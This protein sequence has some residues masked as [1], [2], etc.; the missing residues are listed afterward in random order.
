[1][2]YIF[3]NVYLSNLL[4][5]E[6]DWAEMVLIFSFL[7][8]HFVIVTILFMM[9]ASARKKAL[10]KML[11]GYIVALSMYVILELT[12]GYSYI[13]NK[14]VSFESI[15]VF[16]TL[17][18]AI[19][20]LSTLWMNEE[21]RTDPKEI[22]YYNYQNIGKSKLPYFVVLILIIF[23]I[24]KIVSLNV[25]I[26]LCILSLF[27]LLFSK[28]LQNL[29]LKE[30]LF[31]K[32]QLLNQNL[33]EVIY[34]R[35]KA[36]QDANKKLKTQ[37]EVDSLS[38]LYN[39]FYFF[40][41]IT[42]TIEKHTKFTVLYLDLNKFKSINDLHGHMIGDHVIK[43]IS[44]RLNE[45]SCDKCIISRIGGDEFGVAV[46]TVDLHEVELYANKI[47]QIIE[48]KIMYDEFKFNISASIGIARY[49]EDAT[50]ANDLVRY[51]DLSMYHSKKSDG[52][53]EIFLYNHEL[54]ASIERRKRI[55]WLLGHIDYEQEFELHYQPQYDIFNKKLLGMEALIRWQ[56]SEL[57]FISPAE[58][59]PIAE[60]S[61]YILSITRWVMD[62]AMKKI[63]DWNNRYNENWKMSI[64]ISAKSFDSI[65]FFNDIK[66][67]ISKYKINTKWLDF[68]LTEH[69]AMSA[70]DN[71]VDIFEDLSDL[72]IGVSI[73][74]FGT[75]YS[76]LSYLKKF[77]VNR[78]KI[79][80]ELVDN[81]V[82]DYKDQ[83]I[84]QAII[85]MAKG[86]NLSVIAEGVE[87]QAQLNIL[88]DLGC[89]SI[90]GYIWGK[91]M[92][93]DI[94]ENL[95]IKIKD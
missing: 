3:Y 72:G 49:P 42:K 70:V 75:G 13:T 59:I 93:E 57:G 63:I 14:S 40:D 7:L 37:S 50:T 78:I 91:P 89:D 24:F 66:V 43:V 81:I 47:I 12:Y 38:G 32:E 71:T 79:A 44:K 77:K 54:V 19:F 22:K 23:A 36:L 85:T 9:I 92:P 94:F 34:E 76:S 95:L 4:L 80:K 26:M 21:Q 46:L 30:Q 48:E 6:G 62:T 58:F 25:I 69:S 41:F 45:N 52:K 11:K 28:Y 56:N 16:Y 17:S 88:M 5:L 51:A 73:D 60:E 10:N 90:Q 1:M 31:Y 20:A 84:I 86:L 27:Y 29:L 2:Y 35:T 67:T 68:E 82:E 65:N 55:E 64:N 8:S 15:D 74:D 18:F 33:E 83:L 53:K 61:G 87:S 39:R